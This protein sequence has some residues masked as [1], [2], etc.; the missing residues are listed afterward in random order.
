LPGGKHKTGQ[1]IPLLLRLLTEV[2]YNRLK[3]LAF[4][5][6]RLAKVSHWTWHRLIGVVKK[7]SPVIEWMIMLVS[8]YEDVSLFFE[9]L[10]FAF[11]TFYVAL[12]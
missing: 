2:V 11:Q 9:A 8:G 12:L 3:P 4:F 10:A 1:G 7:Y 5:R 6:R